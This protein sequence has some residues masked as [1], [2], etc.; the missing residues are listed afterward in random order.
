MEQFLERRH[1]AIGQNESLDKYLLPWLVEENGK[2]FKLRPGET[3]LVQLVGALGTSN[4]A[5]TNNF[6]VICSWEEDEIATFSISGTVTLDGSPVDGAKVMVIE[7]DDELM[8]NAFLREVI[9]TPAGG[10]WSSTIRVGKVGAAFVQYKSG[11]VY[12]TAPG[13]PFLS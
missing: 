11:A 5:L 7:A 6:F 12:Y 10:T 3:L 4:A 1:T 2:E 8:T 13:S 9:T